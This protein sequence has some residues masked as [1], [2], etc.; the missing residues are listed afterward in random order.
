MSSRH[1]RPEIPIVRAPES[2]ESTDELIE[3]AA[4][5]L[6][7]DQ[8]RAEHAEGDAPTPIVSEVAGV[9][10][11]IHAITDLEIPQ[12]IVASEI[13]ETRS[14]AWAMHRFAL[15]LLG[16]D[17]DDPATLALA[18]LLPGDIPPDRD[19]PP[20]APPEVEAL[21]GLI[22]DLVAHA[23]AAL[24][25]EEPDRDELLDVC[26][27]TGR[28]EGEPGWLNVHFRMSDARLDLRRAGWDIDPGYVAW[29][30]MVIR[31]VYDD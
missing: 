11:L 23:A 13:F 26:R 1:T 2:R 24:K 22:D 14:L 4:A 29:I 30:G 31:Y 6:T 8:R 10:L 16:A 18:G 20:A 5:R 15:I 17:A 25:W 21:E 9:M 28:F 12:R 19:E 3:P 27:Q 7:P